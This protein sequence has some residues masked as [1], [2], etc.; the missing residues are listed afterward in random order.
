MHRSFVAALVALLTYMWVAQG[1]A[2][3]IGNPFLKGVSSPQQLADIIEQQLKDD[4][5]GTVMIDPRRCKEVDG[6][7]AAPID[8]LEMFKV[9]DPAAGLTSVKQLPAYLRKL[10]IRDAPK[11][12]YWMA[13]L[14]QTRTSRTGWEAL[15]N[16]I[17]RAAKPGE[18]FWVNPETGR[19]VLAEDCTNPIGQLEQIAD[20]AYIVFYARKGD[21]AV[22][23]METGPQPIED[24][25]CAPALKRPGE[26]DFESAYV[27]EC[28]EWSCDM[29]R[30]A[31]Y[32][33]TVRQRS[34]SVALIP[35]EYVLRVPKWVT[36][37]KNAAYRFFFCIERW[38]GPAP[39]VPQYT[40]DYV[41]NLARSVVYRLQ[42]DRWNATHSCSIGVRWFDYL[43]KPKV[44]T[45]R[46][47]QAEARRAGTR[48]VTGEP[49]VLWWHWEEDGCY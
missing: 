30:V 38:L 8:Y 42:Y 19:P 4:A 26:R 22:R 21:T 25:Q 41:G 15:H 17:A 44:A 46:Y 6:S 28:P 29:D 35:G 43:G 47:D 2:A 7:C 27:E 10:E 39:L 3:P 1:E 16:C 37:E 13:C 32:H 14:K 36:E 9:D 11:G 24:A 45:I 48:T 31:R 40:S 20:C 34:G 33:G 5:T 18:K 12:R 49:S 23:F